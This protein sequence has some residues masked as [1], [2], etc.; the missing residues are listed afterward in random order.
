MLVST[1][2]NDFLHQ[3]YNLARLGMP[4]RLELGIRQCAVHA[5]LKLAAIR[6]NEGQRIDFW[7]V[8]FQKLGCQTG[9]AVRVVSDSAISDRDLK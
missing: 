3:I 6:W 5:N 7:L 2:L 4:P 9:S 1:R 8:E